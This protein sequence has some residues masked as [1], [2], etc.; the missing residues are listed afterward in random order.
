MV[1]VFLTGCF[2]EAK[3]SKVEIE[4]WTLQLNAF[5]P[6]IKKVIKEYENKNPDV[7]IKW[8]DI[9]FSEGEKRL[10]A[11]V[12]SNDV[13]DVVNMTPSFSSTLG[14]RGALQ[15]LSGY[16]SNKIYKKYLDRAWEASSISNLT[17][18]IPWYITSPI[19]IYNS[20]LLKNAGISKNKIPATYGQLCELAQIIKQKTD[21]YG[22]M[23][24][25][26]EDGY[27]LKI[28]NKYNIPIISSDHKKALFNSAESSKILSSWVDMYNNDIIPP[29]SITQGH[30]SSLERFI[31]GETAFIITGANFL[32]IIKENSP[33]VYSKAGISNQITGPT[34]KASFSLMNLVIPERSKEKEQAL[35]FALFITNDKNQLE[36]CKLAPILP[37]SIKALESYY[38]KNKDSSDLFEV[39][40]YIS[41]NQLKNLVKPL[42]TLPNQKEL[43]QFIDYAMQ[44]ALLKNKTSQEALDRAAKEW[45]KILAD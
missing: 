15:D 40:R 34:N 38:F 20:R 8:V 30:R 26:A 22:F 19:T 21:K 32:K 31:A 6:Y 3:S 23:P 18:G 9:P 45:D 35:D 5:S 25:L 16:I 27:F 1:C 44:Q 7:K 37:S 12:M 29:E 39:S 33:D 10:L 17:F 2:K 36:F 43:N 13:P 14:A 42:P 4:F 28:L 11:S 24:N 41:A